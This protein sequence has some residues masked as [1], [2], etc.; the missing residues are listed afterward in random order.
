VNDAVLVGEL[1]RAADGGDD[2][3]R[4]LRRHALLDPRAQVATLH[5]LHRHVEVTLDDADVVHDDDVAVAQRR[6]HPALVEQ[7]IG[8]PRRLGVLEHLER[9][10]AVERFL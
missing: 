1:Q 7:A 8:E 3:E 6:D 5:V 2:L 9:D 4:A 10:P